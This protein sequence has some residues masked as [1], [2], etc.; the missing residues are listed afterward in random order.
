MTTPNS[1]NSRDSLTSTLSQSNYELIEYLIKKTDSQI[2]K[3][4]HI[5]N[6]PQPF[7]MINPFNF[8]SDIQE[9]MNQ[10]IYALR[11]LININKE[12]FGKYEETK[13]IN[14]NL[15]SKI[16]RIVSENE[17]LKTQLTNLNNSMNNSFKKNFYKPKTNSNLINDFKENQRSVKKKNY[18]STNTSY[19]GSRIRDKVLGLKT[20]NKTKNITNE[21]FLT[22]PLNSESSNVKEFIEG[23]NTN[24]NLIKEK[25]ISHLRV[26]SG[27][28]PDKY[29]IKEI[30]KKISENPKLKI[31][32]EQKYEKNVI[33]SISNQNCDEKMIEDLTN[34]IKDFE[35]E[36]KEAKELITSQNNN[37][38][39]KE[40]KKENNFNTFSN[41]IN[42]N[43]NKERENNFSRNKKE[44]KKKE[45]KSCSYMQPLKRKKVNVPEQD[46]TVSFPNSLRN[47]P[48]NKIK[49]K[50]FNNYVNPYGNLFD[51]IK[52]KK[53]RK[54]KQSEENNQSRMQGENKFYTY[55]NYYEFGG[56]D[57]MWTNLSNNEAV[58]NF[59]KTNP[60]YTNE[61]EY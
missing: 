60:D 17:S 49:K 42:T 47:Y 57:N 36:E 23:Y 41:V 56:N 37:S 16:K 22:E 18:H 12:T 14:K 43:P 61:N 27:L 54:R 45:S 50:A 34:D 6:I 21:Y 2:R 11:A 15:Q 44:E 26:H 32:L 38:I 25:V 33:E 40:E 29:S 55:G 35:I 24:K 28:S 19:N 13:I 4:E 53:E 48:S 46:N 31:K 20:K 1:A 58:Y 59:N 7:Q 39:N 5:K 9:I 52:N 10:G 30:N 3:V 8:L 51:D